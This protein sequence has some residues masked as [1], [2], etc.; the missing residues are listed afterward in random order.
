VGNG[1]SLQNPAGAEAGGL[2]NVVGGGNEYF[3]RCWDGTPLGREFPPEP[4]GKQSIAIIVCTCVWCAYLL[5]APHFALFTW[6]HSL[7]LEA[8]DSVSMTVEGVAGSKLQNHFVLNYSGYQYKAHYTVAHQVLFALNYF[9]PLNYCLPST[10]VCLSQL[11]FACLNYN[12]VCPQ[13]LFA[14]N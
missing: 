14:L 12:T 9:L 7:Q 6:S 4:M 13:L 11:L 1:T 2:N 5:A 8:A 10:T 3:V